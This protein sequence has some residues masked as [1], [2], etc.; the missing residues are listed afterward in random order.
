[1]IVTVAAIVQSSVGFGLGM[2][3]APILLLID[4]NLVPAPLMMNGV[5]LSLMIAY[6]DRVGIDLMGLKLPCRSNFWPVACGTFAVS[7]DASG[8]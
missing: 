2:I 6:R 1:M 3:A 4:P 7:G 5:V 8:V